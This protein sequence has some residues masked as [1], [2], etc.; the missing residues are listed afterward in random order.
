MIAGSSDYIEKYAPYL[1][2]RIMR[3]LEWIQ[4]MDFNNLPEGEYEI[5]GEDIFARIS[6]Y[7]TEAKENRG[8]ER[9]E[10]YIDVQCILEGRETVYYTP[11]QITYKLDVHGEMKEDTLFYKDVK[12]NNSVHLQAGDFAVFYPWEIHRPNC[13]FADKPEHVKKVVVKVKVF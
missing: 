7:D 10:K 1:D 13:H 5:L 11:Y 12:E 9:H 3:A 6:E 8:A 4:T 2:Y